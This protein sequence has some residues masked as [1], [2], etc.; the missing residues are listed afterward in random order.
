MGHAMMMMHTYIYNI[1]TYV[2]VFRVRIGEVILRDKLYLN[3]L[4]KLFV[5]YL[6]RILIRRPRGVRSK[7]LLNQN[8]HS[9]VFVSFTLRALFRFS[10]LLM[11]CFL[12]INLNIMEISLYNIENYDLK[13][14]EH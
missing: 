5:Y 11:V 14:N 4:T 2:C 1:I 12:V 10:Y 13:Y 7:L 8:V 9:R 3:G 6:T